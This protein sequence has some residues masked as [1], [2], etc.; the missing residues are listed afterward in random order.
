M[1]CHCYST[2]YV[3]IV[4]CRKK[5]IKQEGAV[6]EEKNTLREMIG[7]RKLCS[8]YLF[9]WETSAITSFWMETSSWFLDLS[10]K[11]YL[12]SQVK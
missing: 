7:K 11:E 5:T 2:Y 9:T 6:N 8:I 4:E 12:V 10:A 1:P 3:S